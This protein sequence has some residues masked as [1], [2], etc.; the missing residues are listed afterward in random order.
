MIVILYYQ[1]ILSSQTLIIK[2][3]LYDY[4]WQDLMP[5]LNELLPLN[6]L[7]INTTDVVTP[8]PQTDEEV[9]ETVRAGWG[10]ETRDG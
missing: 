6:L 7:I 2:P 10:W 1:V 5:T 4:T 8:P 9:G 3:E